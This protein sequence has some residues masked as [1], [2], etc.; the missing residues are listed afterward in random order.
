[1]RSSF[2]SFR[3]IFTFFFFHLFPFLSGL[4]VVG[5]D[6]EHSSNP[7][8]HLV[9]RAR[10]YTSSSSE[11]QSPMGA[12]GPVPSFRIELYVN[13]FIVHR[14]EGEGLLLPNAGEEEEGEG[15]AGSHG[16]PV[17]RPLTDPSNR[18]FVE[19]LS[20]GVIPREIQRLIPPG[21][22]VDVNIEDKRGEGEYIAPRQTHRAFQGEAHVMGRR[23]LT[24]EERK[25]MEEEEGEEEGGG[26]VEVDEN[27][28]TASIL[29]RYTPH[30]AER[31]QKRQKIVLNNH[32]TCKDLYKTVKAYVDETNSSFLLKT[33]FPPS[34]LTA[35]EA[36]IESLEL[37]G[38]QISLEW[39]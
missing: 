10:N 8:D 26:E 11:R 22:E 35:M 4:S 20:R 28:P 3:S 14:P 24:E 29:L 7:M 34:S 19:Q 13:G 18:Q 25:G 36:T 33:G 32:H 39:I 2:D 30:P 6:S 37:D 31:K 21:A 12:T 15:E 1:M 23:E 9:N 38:A 17:F 16:E 27:E 5:P